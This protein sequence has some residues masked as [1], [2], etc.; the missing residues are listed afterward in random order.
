[1]STAQAAKLLFGLFF[2][3]ALLA[4]RVERRDEDLCAISTWRWLELL[5]CT[6]CRDTQ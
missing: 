4:R 3:M 1:M 2:F 6:R 5:G